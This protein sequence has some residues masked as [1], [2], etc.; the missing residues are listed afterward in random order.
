MARVLGVVDLA[1]KLLVCCP[2]EGKDASQSNEGQN[3]QSPHIGW[4]AAILLLLHDFRSHVTR[5][6][7]E[8]LDLAA[9]FNAGAE[10]EVYEFRS[11]VI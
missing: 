3:A 2:A 11:Q 6:A 8:D 1:V 9:L 4:L 5:R 10:A 7:A